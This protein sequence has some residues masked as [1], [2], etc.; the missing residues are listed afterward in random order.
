[1]GLMVVTALKRK[2]RIFCYCRKIFRTALLLTLSFKLDSLGEAF[3]YMTK[4]S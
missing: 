3:E 2:Y 4:E 1:M